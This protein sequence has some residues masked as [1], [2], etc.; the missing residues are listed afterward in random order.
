MLPAVLTGLVASRE[1]QA[2]G[3]VRTEALGLMREK[4]EL[5]RAERNANWA[6]LINGTVI[7]TVRDFSRRTVISDVIKNGETD[8]S[9]KQ[10]EVSVSWNT[11]LPNQ[12]QA[13]MYLTRYLDNLNYV[14]TTEAEFNTGTKTGTVVTNTAG[15]EVTL[16]GGGSGNWCEPD[17]SISALDLPKSG[18]ANALTA[19]EGKAFAGTG[20]N[21]SGVSFA[22]IAISN[23]TPPVASVVGTF[24]GFKTNGVFGEAGYAYLATDSNFKEVEIIDLTTNPYSEAGYFNAP[25]NGAGNSVWVNGNVGYMTDGAKLYTFDLSSKSGSRNQLGSVNLAG[26]GQRVVVVGTYAYVVTE[27]TAN[28]LQIVDVS[29]PASMSVVGQTALS[30]GEGKDVYVNST[31]TRAYVATAKSDTQKELFVVDTSSKT[32]SRPTLG[33]YEA[34]GMNP[35]GVAAVSGNK[36]I[37]VGSGGEEYQVIDATAESTPSRCGGL[38]VDTGINGVA[39]VSEADGDAYAYIITGDAGSEFKI[40]AGGPGGQY[41]VS[42]TFESATF[43]AGYTSAF[44][45][46]TFAGSKPANT[47]LTAQIAVSADCNGFVFVGPDGTSGTFFDGLGQ[48]V[49]ATLS[50]GRCM[51]YKAFLESTDPGAAPSLNDITINYSP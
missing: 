37:L 29:N 11:P 32:G 44:N 2:Q 15:G 40:I 23:A 33:S 10:V 16:A 50:S 30:A 51:R 9:T 19:I 36:I 42:G 24:D 25:G 27:N 41:S 22:N 4:L 21:A 38:Q 48:A 47:N 49:D 17:L 46:L 43:D 7:E 28:Q 34:N 1:G 5:V 13:V 35:K 31:G 3:E 14:Q 45:R 20:D 39:A 12:V 18:V 6:N 26:E 8:P